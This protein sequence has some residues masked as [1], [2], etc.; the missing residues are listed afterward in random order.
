MTDD[1]KEIAEFLGPIGVQPTDIEFLVKPGK[2]HSLKSYADL[3][4]ITVW[5]KTQDGPT[6]INSTRIRPSSAR[7]LW[8]M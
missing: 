5:A 8:T 1:R 2:E 3:K 6:L 7:K 4:N